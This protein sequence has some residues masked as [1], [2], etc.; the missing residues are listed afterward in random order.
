MSA[1]AIGGYEEL[2]FHIRGIV[3][4][5]LHNGLLSDPLEERS[6]LLGKAVKM[7]KKQKTEASIAETARLEFLGGLYIGDNGEPCVPGE[8]LEAAIRSA[9]K[10]TKDG[11]A[12]QSGLFCDG[13]FSLIYDGPK[14][15]D[16]LWG[17][18]WDDEK[19]DMV[20]GRRFVDRRRVKVGQAAVMRT[21]PIF[22]EWELKFT[23]NFDP[24]VL[25]KRSVVEFVETLGR[26]VG[27]CEMRPR[28]GRFEVVGVS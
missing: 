28:C 25:N 5:I 15:P 27:L 1:S 24:S 20:A 13:N 16:G 2:S 19:S 21:R 3:P 8:V 9:A 17:D 7:S 18:R 12:V 4:L 14:D 10:I 6:I 23:V 11:K 22:H 26:R